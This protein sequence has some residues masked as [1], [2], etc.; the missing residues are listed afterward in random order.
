[1]TNK[2]NYVIEML[3]KLY[4]NA[5]CELN[6]KNILE[7]TVAV[8][9]SAQT[10]DKQVNVVTSSLFNKYQTLADYANADLVILEQDLRKIGLFRGKAKNIKMMS[11]IV[12]TQFN[13]IIPDTIEKLITLPGIGRK[14]ANVV[15]SVGYGKPGFAI[16][17]H[18]ERISKRL[19]LVKQEDSINEIEQKLKRRFPREKWS[20]LHHQMIF[21][22]RYF[23][24]ARNP[25]CED[26]VF[27]KEC[28]Y[29]KEIKK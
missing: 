7:L 6:N 21:F 24:I 12:L 2:T 13:G 5:E 27:Q 3:E 4:P 29:Y 28:M 15:I 18:V 22:G 1:M 14:T 10:T 19:R 8:M 20:K 25:K 23:C 11:S 17:T 16:D 26:C 9:L